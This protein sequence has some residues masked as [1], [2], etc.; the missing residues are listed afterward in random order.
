MIKRII[1]VLAAFVSFAAGS[2]HA[3]DTVTTESEFSG[4]RNIDVSDRF[5]I[6]V[7][8]GEKYGVRLT[9]DDIV[10]SYVRSYIKNNTLYIDVDEKSYTPELRK[11][12][13]GKDAIVPLFKAEISVVH[14]DTLFL[15]DNVTLDNYEPLFSDDSVAIVM[16]G[17][18]MISNLE[19]KGHGLVLDMSRSATADV[20]AECAYIDATASGASSLALDCGVRNLRLNTSGSASVRAAG[21]SSLCSVRSRGTSEVRLEGSAGQAELKG[22]GMSAIDADGLEVSVASVILS[23][24]S[25]CTAGADDSLRVDL[26]GGSHL[27]FSGSPE[28][29]IVRILSSSLTRAEEGE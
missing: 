24:R 5:D 3:G 8:R 29:E 15:H 14:L 6:S 7:V 23:G 13:R 10:A 2:L 27:V 25:H 28:I 11:S 12:L 17:A 19:F 18:S 20:K 21:T 1:T 4:F 26:S 22:E 16:D 9:V